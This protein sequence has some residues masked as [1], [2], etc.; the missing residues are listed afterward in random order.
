MKG[1]VLTIVLLAGLVG[2]LAWLTLGAQQ[3]QCEVCMDFKGRKNCAT[4]AAATRDEAM[5]TGRSTACGLIVSGVRDS[6]A[7]DAAQPASIRCR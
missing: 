3:V 5:R 7:C 4:A 1:S 2:I 6:F